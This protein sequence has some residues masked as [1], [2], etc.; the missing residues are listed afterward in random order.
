MHL[1]IP[2]F[3]G[4][5]GKALTLNILDLN[6]LAGLFLLVLVTGMLA[7]FYPALYL[8]SFAPVQ[9]MKKIISSPGGSKKTRFKSMQI[10]TLRKLLVLIQ[11]SVS[12]ALIICSL[13][14]FDQL[15]FIR[16]KSWN[17]GKDLMKDSP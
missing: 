7:G 12:I 1:L 13:V 14:V 6:V 4:L 15:N 11:F 2:L 9:V 16:A 8:S 10:G 3:N 5:T 17:S